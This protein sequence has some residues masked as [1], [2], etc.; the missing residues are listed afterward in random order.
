M[1]VRSQFEVPGGLNFVRTLFS[2]VLQL[3]VF[4]YMSKLGTGG[5]I[6]IS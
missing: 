5:A 4:V 2:P 1:Q 3:R 6:I